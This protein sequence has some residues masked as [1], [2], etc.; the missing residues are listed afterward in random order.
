MTNE[1]ELDDFKNILNSKVNELKLKSQEELQSV[2]EKKTTTAIQKVLRNMLVE[3]GISVV[4]TLALSVNFLLQNISS[5]SIIVSLIV[6]ITTIVQIVI[7]YPHYRNL[8]SLNKDAVGNTKM[9]LKSLITLVSAFIKTYKRLIAILMPIGML[10][11][12]IIGYQAGKT[13]D[14]E[15]AFLEIPGTDSNTGLWVL[16]AVVAMLYAIIYLLVVLVIHLLY[17][18]YLKALKAT[19]VQ[20]EES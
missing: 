17:G 8:K 11:G 9:W 5:F 20:I 10:I 3:T 13:N 4:L 16:I 12:M 19:L 7:F 15:Y 14:P 1:M 18:K 6:W 2:I